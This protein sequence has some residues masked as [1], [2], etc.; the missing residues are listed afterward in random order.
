MLKKLFI[1]GA[2]A[3]AVS[4]PLAGAAWADPGDPSGNGLGQ[5][6]IPKRVGQEVVPVFVEFEVA[7]PHLWPAGW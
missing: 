4:V 6:G 7:V 1:T 2:A 5:G 3:A